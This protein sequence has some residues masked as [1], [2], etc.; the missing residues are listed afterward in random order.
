MLPKNGEVYFY[1]VFNKTELKPSI[2]TGNS[3][4]KELQKLS[5]FIENLDVRQFV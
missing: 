3:Q 4:G 1:N 2:K 5:L